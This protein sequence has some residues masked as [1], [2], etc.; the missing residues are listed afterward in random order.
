MPNLKYTFC[1]E[2]QI[3]VLKEVIEQ[4]EI[5][6]DIINIQNYGSGHINTTYRVKTTEDEYILQKVNTN[7]FK[8]M[9]QLVDNVA[10][11]TAYLA[12][13]IAERG[14]NPR[15]ETLQVIH[16]KDGQNYYKG[17][18]GFSYRMYY[19]ITN[20]SCY[21]TVPKPEDIYERAVTF[22]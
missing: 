16:T 3:L 22:G 15:R 11:V 9:E 19:F 13:S 7:I 2:E 14:G 5:A 21:D 18:M 8:N 20:A 17:E 4:F 10:G 1:M 6:G 12:Q